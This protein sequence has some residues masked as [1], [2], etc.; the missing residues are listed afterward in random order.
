[1]GKPEPL[2]V[3]LSPK[4]LYKQNL[5]FFAAFQFFLWFKYPKLIFARHLEFWSRGQ[6]STSK[7][8]NHISH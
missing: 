4:S 7:S 8:R 3:I 1:M 2:S 5:N 6:Y